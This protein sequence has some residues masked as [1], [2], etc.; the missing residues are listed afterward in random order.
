M[1]FVHD[2]NNWFLV[3]LQFAGAVPS[4]LKARSTE[5]RLQA[6]LFEG[7]S[8]CLQF[9]IVE[10]VGINDWQANSTI[11]TAYAEN[12]HISTHD[13]VSLRESCVDRLLSLESTEG[14]AMNTHFEAWCEKYNLR[15]E[16][17]PTTLMFVPFPM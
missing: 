6:A 1:E 13:A 2:K 17:K 12:N 7:F 5:E 8:N 15:N 3:L 9:T 10:K 4:I 14:T 11:W 16:P